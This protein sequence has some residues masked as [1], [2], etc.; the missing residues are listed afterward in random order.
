MGEEELE[1]GGTRCPNRP[2]RPE[3]STRFRCPPPLHPPSVP[4]R[5]SALERRPWRLSRPTRRK[6]G[7]TPSLPQPSLCPGGLGRGGERVRSLRNVQ[8]SGWG[9]VFWRTRWARSRGR[10]GPWSRVGGG[11]E[12]ESSK[13]ASRAF[14]T[15]CS[16]IKT[17]RHAMQSPRT[18]AHLDPSPG[19]G[20]MS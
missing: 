13:Q 12:S 10:A 16:P 4:G 17:V 6:R 15:I 1:E 18:G 14:G 5:P 2:L 20:T 8:R 7:T 19:E 3:E 9:T 11:K